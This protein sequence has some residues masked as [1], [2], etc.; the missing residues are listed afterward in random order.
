MVWLDSKLFE[1]SLALIVVGAINNNEKKN[2][3]SPKGHLGIHE[4]FTLPSSYFYMAGA[5]RKNVV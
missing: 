3:R 4:Y 5:Y 2:L 1:N